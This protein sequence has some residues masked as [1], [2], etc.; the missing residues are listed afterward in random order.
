MICG[1]NKRALKCMINGHVL[2]FNRYFGEN[3]NDMEQNAFSSSLILLLV[4][5][6]KLQ[7]RS[8]EK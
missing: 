7:D 4:R 8:K 3:V 6:G 2:S 1:M 5:V